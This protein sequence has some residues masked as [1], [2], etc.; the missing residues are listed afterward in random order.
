MS[1]LT[2]VTPWQWG[3][4][5]EEKPEEFRLKYECPRCKT[6][7]YPDLPKDSTPK[8]VWRWIQDRFKCSNCG[9]TT[10]VK[11]INFKKNDRSHLKK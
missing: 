11:P 6:M 3:K 10:P 7:N 2:R 4:E 8:T 1:N 5:Q 9:Y